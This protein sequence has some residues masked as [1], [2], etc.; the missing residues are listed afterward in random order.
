[1]TMFKKLAIATVLVAA[2][3]SAFAV[4]PQP[5]YAGIDVASTKIDGLDREGGYGAF[6]G[7]K[8]NGNVA[9]E[10][11]YHRVA[12]TEYRF[13][14]VRA[15]LTLD[16]IDLSVIGTLPLSNGFDLYGR[17]GYNRLEADADIGGF[18]GKEHDSGALYGLGLGYTFSP[19]VHGRLEVQKPASDTTRIVAGV[20]FRF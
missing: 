3:A 19:V 6:F 7:Y 8:F 13:N 2:S 10:G 20:A 17:L 18:S 5:F 4:E 12:D 11:G 15:D 14:G 1:M 9:I 16:M